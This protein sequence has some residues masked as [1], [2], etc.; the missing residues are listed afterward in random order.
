MNL[1]DGKPKKSAGKI[2]SIV[3]AAAGIYNL[4][5]PLLPHNKVTDS[6]LIGIAAGLGGFVDPRRKKQ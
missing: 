3:L 4:L 5:A 2:A 6:V 1:P